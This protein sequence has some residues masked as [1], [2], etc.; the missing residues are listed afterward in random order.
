MN[1]GTP[2][3]NLL[4]E[5]H[6]LDDDYWFKK[7]NEIVPFFTYEHTKEELLRFRNN[8]IDNIQASVVSKYEDEMS[9]VELDLE[10]EDQ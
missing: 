7:E 2:V 1:T 5:K 3:A 10:W 9:S 6:L 8:L 4:Y